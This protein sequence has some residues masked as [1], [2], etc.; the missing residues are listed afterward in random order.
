MSRKYNGRIDPLAKRSFPMNR[1]FLR[2]LAAL[3]LAASGAAHA[4]DIKG[5]DKSVGACTDFYAYAN[6]TWLQGTEIPAD[7]T[8]W[9]AASIIGRNNEQLLI[10]LLDA[11]VKS[12]PPAGTPLAKVVQY[13]ERGMN[14]AHI[15]HWQLKPLA[16]FMGPIAMLK[17]REE[18]ASL[19]GTLH[20]RGIFPGFAF[21]IEIDRRDSKRYVPELRQGGLGLPD[22]DYYF[23]DDEKSQKVRAAYREHLVKV[24]RLNGDD[25]ATANANAAT[26]YEIETELAKASMTAVERRDLEKTYNKMTPAQLAESAPG[27][28]WKA[29]FAALAAPALPNVVVNQPQF[30]KRF[31]QLVQ[32]RPI[33]QWRPYLRWHILQATSDKLDPR[34]ESL[35]FEFYGKTLRGQADPGPRSKRV[36]DI[37]SGPYGNAPVAEALGQL[38]VNKA[39]PP[40]A[41]ARALQLVQ[42]V[43]AALADRLKTVDWMTEETRTRSLEKLAAMTIKI[44]YPDRWKDLSEANV[45]EHVF[46]DNWMSANIFEHERN[47]KRLDK[48]VDRSEWFM[49]PH[50]VNAYYSG[51]N[52]EIVFPAAILQPPF[53]DAKADDAVNYGAIG[54]IIGHEITHGFDDRGRLFDKDGNMRDWWSEED[55]RRYKERAKK[56]EA[57]YGNFTAID[58]IKVNGALTLGENISDVGGVKIAYLALQKALAQPQPAAPAAD[59]GKAAKGAK[60]AAKTAATR[61]GA[62][63]DGLTPEQRFFISYAQA[64]R[65]T[66][67]PERERLQL[68]TGQHSLHQFRV[69]GPIAHMPEFAKAFSCDPGKTLLSE[70]ERA[71]IW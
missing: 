58:G 53:F 15:R 47:L 66:F 18:M 38:Y 8:F 50:I 54:T 20:T 42:N 68:R 63:I 4:L 46:V 44:G 40:E 65:G 17:E 30:L 29:Y 7:R 23:L 48:P 39:F 2:P 70:G 16:Q 28:P 67:R 11:A 57:Q 10:G 9:G 26:I 13:Y 51:S 60:A 3:L 43:K 21:E 64:W 61:P 59:K 1:T 24:L 56:I 31:A 27:F 25:E 32:E 36:L 49:S 33:E 52:N 55:A 19:I 14:E 5:L 62:P 12:P 69:Y 45:G 34:Y 37:I 6:R 41:K 71:N 22:R 35:A